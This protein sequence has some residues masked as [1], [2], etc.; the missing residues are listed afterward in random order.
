MELNEI[1]KAYSDHYATNPLS[2]RLSRSQVG[3]EPVFDNE[4][5]GMLWVPDVAKGR[6]SQGIVKYIG[7]EVVDLQIGD[8][9][10]FSGYN[11]DLVSFDSELV[12]IMPE[13][14]I[15][16]RIIPTPF[17]KMHDG[18]YTYDAIMALIRHQVGQLVDVRNKLESR[19][20]EV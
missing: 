18:E 11:G 12:I 20:K 2:L 3:I 16:A 9:V 4:K 1:L 10:I 19:E 13:D 14:F 7:P 8:F 17:I 15:Q 6:C 5:I